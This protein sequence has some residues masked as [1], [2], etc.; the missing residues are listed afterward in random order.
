MAWYNVTYSCG[1]DGR[2]QLFGKVKVCKFARSPFR[3]ITETDLSPLPGY[4]AKG[5][6]AEEAPE[7]LYRVY[8]FEKQR[9]VSEMTK[10]HLTQDAYPCGFS[11]AFLSKVNEAGEELG[12]GIYDCWY[13]ASAVDD[14]SKEYTVY[15]ELRDDYNPEEDDGGD[16]CNW[17]YP[18]MITDED[19]NNVTERCEID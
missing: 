12:T 17:D 13:K 4:I 6:N 19:G 2:V 5:N 10:L 18:W 8:G 14:D 7:Y 1:H 9:E 16:A 3:E 15:W 11:G